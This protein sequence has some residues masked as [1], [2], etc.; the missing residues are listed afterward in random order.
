M[1]EEA[2]GEHSLLAVIDKGFSPSGFNMVSSKNNGKKAKGTHTRLA[3]R[4]LLAMTKPDLVILDETWMH[5]N[6][7]LNKRIHNL[8]LKLYA[9]NNRTNLFPNLLCIC[10]QEIDP[11][12]VYC[13]EQNVSFHIT[14]MNISFGIAIMYA[15]NDHIRRKS[16][17]SN[18]GTLPPSGTSWCFIGDFNV[19][20]G[21]HEY[22]MVPFSCP[23][24]HA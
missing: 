18:L 6:K 24:Y 19:I 9:L 15:S 23:N 21:T 13:S 11:L 3:L 1:I 4:R 22:K 10:R 12:I 8:C 20:L 5:L 7:F 16:L 2:Y 17:W 14:M